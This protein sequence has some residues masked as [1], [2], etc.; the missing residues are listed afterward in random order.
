MS[1]KNAKNAFKIIVKLTEFTCK[2][3]VV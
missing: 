1:N 2:L 3:L